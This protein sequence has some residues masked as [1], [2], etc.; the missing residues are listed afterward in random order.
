MPPP[1]PQQ[2]SSMEVEIDSADIPVPGA[3]TDMPHVPLLQHSAEAMEGDLGQGEDVG[4]AMDVDGNMQMHA[5]GLVAIAHAPQN[6]LAGQV[7]MHVD[8]HTSQDQVPDA[9]D[10]LSLHDGLNSVGGAVDAMRGVSPAPMLGAM[11][12]TDVPIGIG[13]E[14]TDPKAWLTAS[15]IKAE[16][17]IIGGEHPG[18]SSSRGPPK[19]GDSKTD[20]GKELE[21]LEALLPYLQATQ[22][23]GPTLMF[24]DDWPEDSV[25]VCE[26]DDRPVDVARKFRVNL[27][28]LVRMNRKYA[29]FLFLCVCVPAGAWSASVRGNR[30]V[31]SCRTCATGAKCSVLGRA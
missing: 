16:A 6:D 15:P 11:E 3:P 20:S 2:H 10:G 13:S 21:D 18:A 19:G 1:P 8:P 9:V 24:P 27:E 12:Q 29:V 14:S 26:E 4:A 25:Y 17:A 7:A 23:T 5:D 30:T 31:T 28:R 22:M